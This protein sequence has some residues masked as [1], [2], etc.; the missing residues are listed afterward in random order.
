[1]NFDVRTTKLNLRTKS[2]RMD[3]MVSC[4]QVKGVADEDNCD[5]RAGEE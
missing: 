4:V 5:Y 3:V 1:M 2:R